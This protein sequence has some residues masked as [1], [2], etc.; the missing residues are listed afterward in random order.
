MKVPY[1]KGVADHLG[2]ESCAGCREAAGEALTGAVQ[3]GLSSRERTFSGVLTSSEQTESN[4]AGRVFFSKL[5]ADSAWSRNLCM[6][7]SISRGNR[8]LPWSPTAVMA[9][10][11]RV[12]KSVDVIR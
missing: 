8:E 11:G 5:P 2:P 6:Y 1:E 10:A 4:I 12:G 3:A 9:A 7:R